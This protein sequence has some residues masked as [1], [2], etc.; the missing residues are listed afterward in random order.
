LTSTRVDSLGSE[1]AGLRRD[2]IT[3]AGYLVLATWGWFLYGFGALLPQLGRDQGISRTLT[4]VHSVMMA[5][6]ALLAGVFA[7]P[8]VRALRR[9]GVLR[10]GG[11]LVLC[12]TALLVV[13]GA[14][15]P[16]T[17]VAL[18]IAGTGGA[19]LVNTAV[20]TMTAHHHEHGAAALA[21]AN[22]VAAS[23]GLIAPL[24][25]GA[26]IG[27][28]LSWRPAI[29]VTVPLVLAMFV[30]VARQ[31]RDTPALDEQLPPRQGRA[32]PLPA[33]VWPAAAMVV[34]CVGVE[35]CLTNW[36]ADLLRE[37]VGFSAGAAAAGV[38][39]VIGGMTLGRV[40]TGRM[41]LRYSTRRLLLVAIL[42][43]LMGWAGTWLAVS[44]WTALLGLF[45]TGV[46]LGALYPLGTA[47]VL[48][49]ASGQRDQAAG[50][51]SIGV[52]LAAGG[53]PFALGA[54]ADA[55]STHLAFL[56]VP[57]LLVAAIVLL[58]QSARLN[59]ATPSVA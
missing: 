23:C 32:A 22:A 46:G 4:G 19:L 41:A 44:G 29:L 33:A 16:V 26:G 9:R 35:F 49:A 24:L 11:V 7:V 17:L 12:G 5:I 40:I 15:T 1:P 53:G 28:G 48:A 31:P 47:I 21:E 54:L 30:L 38:S 34:A 6:G 13:G 25:V 10:L 43:A 2:G 8:L 18:L 58:L 39:A 42:I 37:Q 59:R 3:A 50:V 20:T 55:S 27:V 52:G 57:A 36:S 45:V 14:W 56:V 51:L